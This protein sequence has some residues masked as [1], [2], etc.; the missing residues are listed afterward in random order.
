[1]KLKVMFFKSSKHLFRRMYVI[2]LGQT[3]NNNVIN[4]IF[5]KTKTYQLSIHDLLKFYMG[6]FQTKWYKLPLVQTIFPMIINSSKSH[7]NLVTFFQW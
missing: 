7:F 2:S 1:M 6:I 5:D 3:K 4:V